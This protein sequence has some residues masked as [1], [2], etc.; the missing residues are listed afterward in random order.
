M[1]QIVEGLEGIVGELSPSAQLTLE[2]ALVNYRNARLI[3]D[4]RI[5]TMMSQAEPV[6]PH[7]A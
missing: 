3:A 6:P 7:D 1:D 2:T 4:V 5:D